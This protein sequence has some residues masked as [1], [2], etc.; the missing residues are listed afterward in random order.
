M[1]SNSSGV[2]DSGGGHIWVLE[3]WPVASE[4]QTGLHQ[5]LGL[6]HQSLFLGS[7]GTGSED[8][9]VVGGYVEQVKG[10]IAELM[11]AGLLARARKL[12]G[13]VSS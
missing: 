5:S 10:K 6:G 7:A 8:D 1:T 4:F 2:S 12:S 9:E 3:D 11:E 13:R